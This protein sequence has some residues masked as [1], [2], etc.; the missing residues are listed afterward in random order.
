MHV[1][2]N[3]LGVLQ[4]VASMAM[5]L[6]A[7]LCAGDARRFAAT[8]ATAGQVDTLTRIVTD[9]RCVS[10]LIGDLSRAKLFSAGALLEAA[11][12]AAAS[13]IIRCLIDGEP[14]GLPKRQQQTQT[15]NGL[16]ALA[17]LVDSDRASTVPGL[18]V[19]A[20]PDRCAVRCT[21]ITTTAD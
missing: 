16:W 3:V 8:V 18:T 20:P 2:F 15:G 11:G 4:S 14:P 19:A 1:Y 5:D 6:L 9:D 13:W 12:P 17:R 10:A 7:A 21:I